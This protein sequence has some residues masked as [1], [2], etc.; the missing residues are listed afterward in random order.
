MDSSIAS[1]A[2]LRPHL[3]PGQHPL[4][5]LGKHGHDECT[6][7]FHQSTGPPGKSS[8]PH[9]CGKPDDTQPRGI[10]QGAERVRARG[11]EG[12][13]ESGGELVGVS[14]LRQPLEESR[15]ECISFLRGTSD[16]FADASESYVSGIPDVRVRPLHG[17]P[18]QPRD[19][20]GV[21]GLLGVAG[22]VLSHEAAFD[23]APGDDGIPGRGRLGS[24]RPRR[25]GFGRARL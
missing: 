21:L 1:H 25:I 18:P 10:P 23:G 12:P 3:H 6:D 7:F 4:R 14:G 19:E 8:N 5:E 9:G 2:L 16:V 24:E 17:T 22:G 15:G 11:V 13:R 20:G